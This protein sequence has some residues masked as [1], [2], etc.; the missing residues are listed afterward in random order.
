MIPDLEFHLGTNVYDFER[1]V[2]YGFLGV[3]FVFAE[4]FITVFE[5]DNIHNSV[6]ARVNFGIG[7]KFTE[8]LRMELAVRDLA[9]QTPVKPDR[10]LKILY[11]TKFRI[12][13]TSK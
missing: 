10:I 4:K 12:T 3:S 11:Q 13:K 5:I 1:D 8:S 7:A 6:D 2:I 9:K